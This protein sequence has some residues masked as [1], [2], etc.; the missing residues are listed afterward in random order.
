[1]LG[2]WFD[3]RA[4]RGGD[5][6]SVNVGS[7]STEDDDTAFSNAWGPGFRAI[8]DMA[9]LDR[10]LAVLNTGQSGHVLSPH[11]AD[12][13]PLWSTGSYI[14]LTTDRRAVEDHARGKLMLSPR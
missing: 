5:S 14:P 7:Y 3:V 2:R 8:Y 12:Q 4:K 11:Y 10:S 9:A 13:N 6:S 1:V